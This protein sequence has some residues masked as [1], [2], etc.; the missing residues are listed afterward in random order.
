[1]KMSQSNVSR[2]ID[3]Y[4]IPQIKRYEST[5]YNLLN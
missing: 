3:N 2:P 5:Y 4:Q 1:M